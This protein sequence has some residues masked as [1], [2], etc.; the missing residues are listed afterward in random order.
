MEEIHNL[1]GSTHTLIQATENCIANIE[2]LTLMNT[3]NSI[4]VK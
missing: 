2:D 3:K 4:E 1:K